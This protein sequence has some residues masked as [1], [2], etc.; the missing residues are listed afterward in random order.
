MNNIF[1]VFFAILWE[2]TLMTLQKFLKISACLGDG[3]LIFCCT[4]Q[5]NLSVNQNNN[6]TDFTCRYFAFYY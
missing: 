1:H 2:Q 6:N 4:D 3:N 5:T